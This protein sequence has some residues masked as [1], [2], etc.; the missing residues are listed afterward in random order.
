MWAPAWGG[1]CWGRD[2]FTATIEVEKQ[3]NSSH[4]HC[5][6]ATKILLP[7]KIIHILE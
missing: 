5:E 4:R 3:L 1:K 2:F 7:V 6:I